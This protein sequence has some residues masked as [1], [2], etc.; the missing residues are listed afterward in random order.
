[1]ANRRRYPLNRL[2]IVLA[3]LVVLAVPAPG[4]AKEQ[5]RDAV[6][7]SSDGVP[8]PIWL[9]DGTPIDK[10]MAGAASL[11]STLRGARTEAPQ[12]WLVQFSGPIRAQWLD[13][14]RSLGLE[15]VSY[16]P[17]FAYVVWGDGASVAGLDALALKD[18]SVQWS[19]VYQPAYR[20]SPPLQKAISAPAG[21]A[22]VPVT[23]Q[24]YNTPNVSQSVAALREIGGR[25]FSG[26]EAILNFTNISL[27]L[28]PSELQAVAGWPDVFNVEPWSP[29]VKHDEVQ[30]QLI[31]GNLANVGGLV[32][33]SGPGYLAWLASKGFPTTQASYPVVDIVD[34][35]IDQGDAGAVLHPDLH[36][37]GTLANPDRVAYINDC[38]SG[39]H[40]NG[41][42]GHGN[43]N[44]GIVG[45]YNNR[46]GWPYVDS[47]GYNIG[48]G[49]SPYGRIAG[50]KVFSDTS[51]YDTS[52]CSGNTQVVGAS[53][54]GG[55][56]ITSNSWG[57]ENVAYGWYNADA[58]AYDALTRDAANF[59]PGNQEMLHVFA[60]GN[61]GTHNPNQVSPPGTAK[62][63]LTVGATENVRD[64]GVVD[65]CS[66][67][68]SNSADH[69]AAFSS[70]GPTEDRRAKPDIMAPG[71][72]IQGPASQDP[73]YTGRGVCGAFGNRADPHVAGTQYYP[74]GQTLYTWSSGTSHSTP[75]VAG[76]A[77]L[78]Y[79]YYGRVLNPGRRPS[80]AMLKALLLSGTRFL[81]GVAAYDTLP[82]IHQGWGAVN[83]GILFD[84]MPRVMI[85]QDVVLGGTGQ[86]YRVTGRVADTGKPFR[87]SLVWTDAPGPTT[88]AAYVNDL[89]LEVA[90]G[91]QL[92]RG[93]VFNGAFSVPGGSSDRRNNVENVFLPTGV[94]GSFAVRVTAYN[95]PGDGV[96][97]NANPTDQDFALV[98]D[99]AISE[100]QPALTQAT[101]LWSDGAGNGNGVVEPGET[102]AVQIGLA[103]SGGTAAS[104]VSSTLGTEPKGAAI[105]NGA[106]AYADIAVGATVTGSLPY[107]FTVPS[108]YPCSIPL[109]FR[110]T[111]TY[112]TG[113]AVTPGF[114]IPVGAALLGVTRTNDYA[115]QPVPIP[116]NSPAGA[117]AAASIN[118]AP[119]GVVGHLNA[120]VTI[121]HT[122]DGDLDIYLVSPADKLV[123]LASRRGG[124][125]Q[126][127][128]DT[129][130]DDQ[131]TVYIAQASKAKPPFTGAFKPESPLS[132]LYGQPVGGT[133]TLKVI[134]RA[135]SNDGSIGAFSLDIQPVEYA[136]TSFSGT[137]FV[138]IGR[139]GSDVVLIWAHADTNTGYTVW[140]SA[141]PD[142]LVND[143]GASTV[144]CDPGSGATRT[145]I[146]NSPGLQAYYLVQAASSA[147]ATLDS[148]RTGQFNFALGQ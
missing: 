53:Y 135:S 50:T 59:E 143:P 120:R 76:A 66:D 16:M 103:N 102:I 44:A 23:V 110:Q 147:G 86:Q 2:G 54:N 122:R 68:P 83:L 4:L 108:S 17:D 89:D 85:D 34:D 58:Q 71:I 48:L 40:G 81:P 6:P 43:I 60:A 47:H 36:E 25:V 63:V 31:A 78:L 96:P 7:P 30:D 37:L 127:Y 90:A 18:D 73:G 9:R 82:S 75:A 84:G 12:L 116:D 13:E 80:P 32:K 109:T 125:G 88:G 98:V 29:M 15:I 28:L 20:L 87:V 77:S 27:E 145:C 148:N 46:S 67:S 11:P 69:V 123:P 64:D 93:N 22:M 118:V 139:A 141:Y 35:G 91:G 133:W 26:P 144:A 111:I 95:I 61:D 49:V 21:A 99:N 74:A 101:V 130:F 38:T 113:L 131:A 42:A 24:F 104:G 92:Y 121:T 51:V 39:S 55:A 79:E 94:S 124:G 5:E 138:A 33:P 140:R 97:G 57:V 132:A 136:C 1:M 119:A 114:T 10:S 72:H 41:V 19:G 62:N 142:F 129:I 14:L 56:A 45:S 105:V 146:D 52:H 115:G 107:T 134:D 112:N 126:N 70:R 137:P 128:I 8:A 100:T 3:I 117:S 65:G 106:S